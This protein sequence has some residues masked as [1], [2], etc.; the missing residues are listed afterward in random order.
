VIAFHTASPISWL[1]SIQHLQ[2]RDCFPYNI[3]NFVIAFHTALQYP[4]SWLPPI[5]QVPTLIGQFFGRVY[6]H[7]IA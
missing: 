5:H 1:L 2:F 7:R 3:S 4:I 6:I